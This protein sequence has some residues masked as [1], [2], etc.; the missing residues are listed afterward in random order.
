MSDS[1]PRPGDVLIVNDA[2]STGLNDFTYGIGNKILSGTVCI[3]LESN[4]SRLRT[5][6]VILVLLFPKGVIEWRNTWANWHSW[7]RFA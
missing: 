2:F 6:E 5:G 1:F 7:M 4:E 3:V